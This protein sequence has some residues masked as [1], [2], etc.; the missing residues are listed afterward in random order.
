[1]FRR[2]TRER[3][4]SDAE[5]EA[6]MAAVRTRRHKHQPRDHAFFA[7]LANTG[8]RP[9]EARALTTSDLHLGARAPWIRVVRLKRK[10]GP[11]PVTELVLQPAVAE[12]LK[13]YAG[14]LTADQPKPFPFTR[15]QGDRLFHYYRTKAGILHPFRIY[16]LRHTVGMRLWRA[17]RDLRLIQAIF[18]HAQLRATAAYVHVGRERIADAYAQIGTAG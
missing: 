10:H 5:L 1:M 18:G 15:R 2:M 16:A 17:T 6:F 4:L 7:L 12:V 9:S 8:I 11:A 3:Y 13:R 14:A